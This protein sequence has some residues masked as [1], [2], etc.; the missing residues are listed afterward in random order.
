MW[1]IYKTNFKK[2]SLNNK[3]TMFIL[4]KSKKLL[5]DNDYL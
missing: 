3:E 1:N 2:L 5:K 4:E